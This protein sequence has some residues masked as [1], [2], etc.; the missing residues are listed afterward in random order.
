MQNYI[1]GNGSTVSSPQRQ[2]SLTCPDLVHYTKIG[3]THCH[4][5][6]W[7]IFYFMFFYPQICDAQTYREEYR[8]YMSKEGVDFY[9][10]WKRDCSTCNEVMNLKIVN[11]NSKKKDIHLNI[12]WLS[13]GMQLSVD[14]NLVTISG[15]STQSGDI[16]G[17]YYYPPNGYSKNQVTFRFVDLY[18]CDYNVDC[19]KKTYSSGRSQN[20][21]TS[22]D[23]NRQEEAENQR[24]QQIADQKQRELEA[25]RARAVNSYNQSMTDLERRN[26]QNEELIQ[27]TAPLLEGMLNTEHPALAT[28]GDLFLIGAS[29]APPLAPVFVSNTYT[30]LSTYKPGWSFSLIAL[31]KKG[32]SAISSVHYVRQNAPDFTFTGQSTAGTMADFS[33]SLSAETMQ[34]SLSAGKDFRSKNNKVHLYLGPSLGYIFIFDHV[35]TYGPNS[36]EY[37]Q[38][39]V[40][41]KFLYGLDGKLA[42]FLG[43]AFGIKA[44]Y[45]LRVLFKKEDEIMN[46]KLGNYT[47][48]DAGLFFRISI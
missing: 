40:K 39:G 29:F 14:K 17:K 20:G 32:L 31:N 33:G 11:N 9:Y 18:I 37:R 19:Y 2:A 41:D 47:Y 1:Y 22:N 34:I 43:E 42:L 38:Q 5:I 15:G 7:L 25:Q 6:G 8:H 27:Q 23:R 46:Y 30:S 36:K 10:R 12:Q 13:N 16:D 26:K 3:G 35:F 21:Q 44:G 4:L 28:A 48:A 24:R 45:S